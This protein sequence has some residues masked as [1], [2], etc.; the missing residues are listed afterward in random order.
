MSRLH[1]AGMMQTDTALIWCHSVCERE[2]VIVARA[3][4]DSDYVIITA[5]SVTHHYSGV[6]RSL[7]AHYFG[8]RSMYSQ[9]TASHTAAPCAGSITAS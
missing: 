9:N 5:H 8:Q 3:K 7:T 2:I 6:K 1:E 4:H